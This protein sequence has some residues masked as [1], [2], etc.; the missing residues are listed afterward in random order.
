MRRKI[1]AIIASLLCCSVGIGNVYAEDTNKMKGVLEDEEY[2]SYMDDEVYDEGDDVVRYNGTLTEMLRNLNSAST[3]STTSTA[4]PTTNINVLTR[5]SVDNGV[6][7][8]TGNYAISV[9]TGSGYRYDRDSYSL[10]E[11][12][13]ILVASGVT[14]L[15]K[16][17][18]T[19]GTVTNTYLKSASQGASYID[20]QK[21]LR[22]VTE[23]DVASIAIVFG[24]S[25]N[26]YLY[27]PYRIYSNTTISSNYSST[28]SSYVNFIKKSKVGVG[29]INTD[30]SSSEN[31]ISGKTT[32][33]NSNDGYRA[34][35]NITFSGMYIDIDYNYE[36]TTDDNTTNVNVIKMIHASDITVSNCEFHADKSRNFRN[37]VIEFTGVKD[38]IIDDCKFVADT[39]ETMT[40][41][42]VDST[43]F[44]KEAVQI[45]S[46]RWGS[47]PFA[48]FP[49][50]FYNDVYTRTGNNCG[51]IIPTNV[52]NWLNEYNKS[53]NITIS[54][55]T[56][57]KVPNCVGDHLG[58]VLNNYSTNIDLIDNNFYNS[59]IAIHLRSLKNV[60]IS[61]CSTNIGL[62]HGYSKRVRCSN[63]LADEYN[64]S[65]YTSNVTFE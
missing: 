56:F 10:N 28:A 29:F 57:N 31:Y 45:E 26:V 58:S 6:G 50:P 59:Q 55:C 46:A 62:I 33:L 27:G 39:Y 4:V 3:L 21:A 22:K 42:E 47:N 8:S 65:S 16:T 17:K 20:L 48:K 11:N 9:T 35:K 36:G 38:S 34:A 49:D 5:Y 53:D 1:V 37:H 19:S 18:S 14:V 43:Y 41:S 2:G 64:N 40:D 32:V 51:F 7:T 44:K 54:N 24:G 13:K 23:S 52:S 25:G 15:L 63:S 61:G 30:D 12:G 60:T